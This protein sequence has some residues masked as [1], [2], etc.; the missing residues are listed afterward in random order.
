[1]T[2]QPKDVIPGRCE[3]SNPESRDSGSGANAPS[4]NDGV[5][6]LVAITSRPSDLLPALH[7]SRS[8]RESAAVLFL[9]GGDRFQI[10][11]GTRHRRARG[12]DVPLILDLVGGQRRDR[13]HFVHQLMI[14]GAEVALPRL[15]NI[16]FCTL[17]EVLDDFW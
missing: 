3:A 16:E 6:M 11:V 13:I 8:A 15:Q 9:G 17:L 4:R 2:K 12:E 5:G 7:L 10:F 14:R 1:M